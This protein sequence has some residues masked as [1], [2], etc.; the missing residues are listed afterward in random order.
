[1]AKWWM[2]A[3]LLASWLGQPI[4]ARAQYLPVGECP[5]AQEEPMPLVGGAPPPPTAACPPDLT[6]SPNRPSAFGPDEEY[7]CGPCQG[8]GEG[9]AWYVGAGSIGLTRQGLGHLAVATATAPDGSQVLAEDTSSV[10]VER[11]NFG[12]KATVGYRWDC[13]AIEASGFYIPQASTS[14][15]QVNPGA[16]NL[17][18]VNF[19]DAFGGSGFSLTGTDAVTQDY[20]TTLASAEVNYRYQPFQ[21]YGLELLG[22]VRYLDLR[23]RYILQNNST[24]FSMPPTVPADV[25]TYSTR[26]HNRIVAGQFGIDWEHPLLRWLAFGAN[27]KGAWGANF[28]DADVSL[29]RGDGLEQIGHRSRTKFSQI[30]E[31]GLYLDLYLCDRARIRGGYNVLWAVGV[32]EPLNVL[33]FDLSQVNGQMGDNGTV[34]Y[35]GPSLELHLLF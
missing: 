6:L 3:A 20:Q 31:A 30:Y 9:C 12:V 7:N 5:P 16:L 27:V 21:G 19:P 34:F 35:H 13:H 11:V 29:E 23:E 8:F 22:G 4:L 14:H 33:S 28:L 17:P 1:M 15:G 24:G 25:I 10:G 32:A 26:T 2:G 18:F